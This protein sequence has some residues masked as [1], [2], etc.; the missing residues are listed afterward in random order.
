MLD[1][2]LRKLALGMAILIVLFS[3]GLVQASTIKICDC[4][5]CGCQYLSIQEGVDHASPGDIVL[6]RG[7]IYHENVNVTKSITLRGQIKGGSLPLM[8]AGGSGSGIVVSADGVTIEDIRVINA[9]NSTG[10]AGI[11]VISDNNTITDNEVSKNGWAGIF[12]DSS[13]NN[14]V[15]TNVVRGNPYGI[16]LLDASDNHL[17]QNELF[18]NA[19]SDAFDNGNNEWDDWTWVDYYGDFGSAED[20]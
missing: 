13:R 5:A 10:D 20:Y 16:Y 12:I 17:S 2:K 19:V 18:E 9:G 15:V 11:K 1:R 8:D 6:V 7:G 14:T 3:A 4:R